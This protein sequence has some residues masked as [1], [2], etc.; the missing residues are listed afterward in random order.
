MQLLRTTFDVLQPEIKKLKE[1]MIFHEHAIRVFYQT[2][3]RQIVDRRTGVVSEAL[4]DSLIQVI[5]LLLILDALKDMKS[6]LNNDFSQYKRYV[7]H[8]CSSF[9]SFLSFL[10]IFSLFSA[11]SQVRGELENSDAVSD[12]IQKLQ[13]FLGNPSI[14][15]GLIMHNLRDSIHRVN[16][17]LSPSHFQ[18]LFFSSL[19]LCLI[20]KYFLPI[21]C[22]DLKKY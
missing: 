3:Q 7:V 22:I 8:L 17:F 9:P 12:E 2:V 20:V 1:L 21:I 19:L 10:F 11:F 14:P 4:Y 6:C 18:S 13:M 16:G 15:K 5:D